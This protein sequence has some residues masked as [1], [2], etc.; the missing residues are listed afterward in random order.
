MIYDLIDDENIVRSI[1]LS[2]L[3][4]NPHFNTISSYKEFESYFQFMCVHSQ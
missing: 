3:I 2:L 4:N 1:L